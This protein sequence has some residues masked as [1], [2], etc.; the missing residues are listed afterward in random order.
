MLNIPNILTR[1]VYLCLTFT[2]RLSTIHLAA[3][4]SDKKSAQNTRAR[5]KIASTALNLMHVIE[6]EYPASL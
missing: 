2:I 4:E 5:A 6:I 3:I 1:L